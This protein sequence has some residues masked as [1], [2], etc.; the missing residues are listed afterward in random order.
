MPVP[1]TVDDGLF[2]VPQQN[3][4]AV[5]EYP[6]FDRG[7]STTFIA[8]V[9]MIV[10][11]DY[12]VVPVPMSVKQFGLLGN[13]FLVDLIPPS[14][15]TQRLYEYSLVYANI[16]KTRK[17]PSTVTYTNQSPTDSATLTV[18]NVV[19]F[20]STVQAEDVF[21][22]SVNAP[23]PPLI[24]PVLVAGAGQVYRFGDYNRGATRVLAQNS[25][26]RI[27]MGKIYERKSTFI[28]RPIM[29]GIQA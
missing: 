17:E 5:Y 9:K 24:A 2:T 3:G 22:Y 13:A 19:N 18:A 8:T 14:D 23:L 10:D 15:T 25:E 16:P 6:F 4:A 29:R 7:D 12:F 26:A 28:T 11:L 1:G 27:Y 21:E 20:T